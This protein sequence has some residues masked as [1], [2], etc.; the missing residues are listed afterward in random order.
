MAAKAPK[1]PSDYYATTVKVPRTTE[2]ALKREQARRFL[3]DKKR[4][5]INKLASELV[6]EAAAQLPD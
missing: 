6:A 2:D 1:K 4:I 5:S 3:K